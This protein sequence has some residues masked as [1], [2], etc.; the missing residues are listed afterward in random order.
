MAQSTIKLGKLSSIGVTEPWQVP[1][2]IPVRYKDF[3]QISSDFSP[4]QLCIGQSV[5]LK[6]F[7]KFEPAVKWGERSKTPRTQFVIEGRDGF[8]VGFVIFGDTRKVVEDLINNPRELY[9][10]GIIF[11]HNNNVQLKDPEIISPSFVGKVVGEYQGK[12]NKISPKKSQEII[13]KL[14]P[15]TLALAAEQIQRKIQTLNI[16]NR[17]VRE[18]IDCPQ[19]T[20]NEVLRQLHYPDSMHTAQ[21]AQ[22]VMERIEGLCLVAELRTAGERKCNLTVNRLPIVGGDVMP[23][24]KRFH[25]DATSEQCEAIKRVIEVLKGTNPYRFLLLGDVGVGKS[26]VMIVSA[27]YVAASGERVVML[28]PNQALANQMYKDFVELFPEANSLLVTSGTDKKIDLLKVSVLIGTTALLHRDIGPISLMIT[29][30]EQKLSVGMKEQLASKT[31]HQLIA[32]ATPIPRTTVLAQHGNVEVLRLTKCHV[33]KTI[34]TTLR[35]IEDAF[36]MT[37]EA[38]AV[39]INGGKLLIVCPKRVTEDLGDEGELPSAEKIGAKWERLFP[40]LVRIAHSGLS[41]EQNEIAISDVKIGIA[42]VLVS[43]SVVEVGM[44]IPDLWMVI[45]VDAARFGLTTLH[46]IRG[47]LIRN[48]ENHG[49][50]YCVL[51]CPK[52]IKDKTRERLQVLVNESDGYEIAKQDMVMRGIGDVS[53]KGTSQH[54]AANA[55]CIGKK[56]DISVVESVLELF[57]EYEKRSKRYVA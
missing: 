22:G 46:Q 27:A 6:G 1:L 34:S 35:G 13:L 36:E 28:F 5:V 44:N 14:L 54:G 48:G 52:P 21:I 53:Q 8:T 50:G 57:D 43:T 18:A 2:V 3:S 37:E 47:R 23:L 45:I 10:Y 15:Q 51:Y 33:A 9:V 38:K 19:W 7:L 39:I 12:A 42:K 41:P 40:G 49:Q 24:I 4:H 26:F 11:A 16:D 25:F 32:S 29:D 17:L 20:L 31:T 30:E 56:V 55:M